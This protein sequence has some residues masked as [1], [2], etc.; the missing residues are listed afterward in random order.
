MIELF[1]LYTLN[2]RD[3]TVYSLRRDIIE[4]FGFSTKPSLGTIHPA[5]KRLLK[6]DA[7]KFEQKYSKGGKKSTYYSI[8]PTGKKVFKDLFFKDISENPT[9]FHNQLC[10][11]LLTISMLNS[12]EQN[13]FLNELQK[14]LELQKIELNSA[15]NNKYIEYDKWQTSVLNE[16]LNNINSLEKMIQTLKN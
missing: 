5:L 12:D 14:K 16:S 3:K 9:I 7:V 15:I 2:L 4:R 1:I 13:E 8:T 11:R 6:I 10:A